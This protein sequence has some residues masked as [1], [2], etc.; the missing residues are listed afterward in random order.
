MVY[1]G[2]VGLLVYYFFKS[3]DIWNIIL[4]EIYQ[5]LEFLVNGCARHNTLGLFVP[6]FL[7]SNSNS[8]SNSSNQ[9]DSNSNCECIECIE[10]IKEARTQQSNIQ[11]VKTLGNIYSLI[12][13]ID[14]NMLD[15]NMLKED[16]ELSSRCKMI[17]LILEYIIRNYQEVSNADYSLYTKLKAVYI[18]EA[19]SFSSLENV[20]RG[21]EIIPILE[22]Y[23]IVFNK[24]DTVCQDINIDL[25][26]STFLI[27]FYQDLK[28]IISDAKKYFILILE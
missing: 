25:I 13:N 19:L 16:I 17:Q 24:L 10:C 5:D 18:A 23:S 7:Y 8:N 4:A 26:H 11:N 9:L 1:F 15:K 6:G 3:R 21:I 12:K 22:E 2:I 27:G 14:T 28:T 20:S